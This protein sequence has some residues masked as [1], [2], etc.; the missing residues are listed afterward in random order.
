MKIRSRSL[1]CVPVG[2]TAVL[3]FIGLSFDFPSTRS[4]E[5][6]RKIHRV[7]VFVD[8][9]DK[10]SRAGLVVL[11]IFC[12]RVSVPGFWSFNNLFQ[13]YLIVLSLQPRTWLIIFTFPTISI[14]LSLQTI[15]LLSFTNLCY[16]HDYFSIIK[17]SGKQWCIWLN[18]GW[19]CTNYWE[20]LL[21]SFEV[22]GGVTFNFSDPAYF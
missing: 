12:I 10:N 8:S 9:V 17:R 4:W 19:D 22:R 15:Y 2:V 1:E 5:R 7:G 14:S 6:E 18:W 3:S 21:T 11:S 20:S 13:A 16:G